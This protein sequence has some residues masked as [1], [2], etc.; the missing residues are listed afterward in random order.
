MKRN[1]GSRVFATLLD[2][3]LCPTEFQ[4]PMAATQV[5]VSTE[6]DLAK[7]KQILSDAVDTVVQVRSITNRFQ[8]ARNQLVGDAKGPMLRSLK[9]TE[10]LRPAVKWTCFGVW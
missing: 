1:P 10:V 3:Y 6:A 4:Q 5:L 2:I 9:T 8:R 7:I